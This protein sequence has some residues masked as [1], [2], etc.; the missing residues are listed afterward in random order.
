MAQII[1][2]QMECGASHQ[3]AWNAVNIWREEQGLCCVTLS[4]VQGVI[5]KMKP[6]VILLG[7]HQQGNMDENHTL[8]MSG[9]LCPKSTLLRFLL[10]M[11]SSLLTPLFI[12]KSLTNVSPS[13]NLC[14]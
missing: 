1:A 4:A 7:V 2:D 11:I 10:V 5:R 6:Q 12:K 14:G 13:M 3:I 8:I 9:L